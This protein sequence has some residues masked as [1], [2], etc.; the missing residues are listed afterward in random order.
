M[1]RA[2]ALVTAWARTPDDVITPWLEVLAQ[3]LR[4]AGVELE[5]L[6]PA[7]R[8]AEGGTLRGVRVHRF[9]YAPAPLEVLSHEASVPD[10]LRARP[11]WGAL[12]PGYLAAAAWETARLVE[13][14]RFDLVH[15]F[16]PLPHALPGL[17][18]ARLRGVPL[19]SSFFGVELSLAARFPSLQAP[20]RT[21]VRASDAVT[22]VS[23]FTAARLRALA[24]DVPVRVIPFGVALAPSPGLHAA[25]AETKGAASLRLLFIGR[26]VE[27]KG[28]AVLL[29]AVAR[30]PGVTLEVLGDGPLRVELERR[31]A[32][33]GGRVTFRGFV[34]AEEKA[35]QLAACDA[36]V[37]PAVLD[38]LGDT[39]GQGVVL[40]EAMA[41]GKPVIASAA[42]GIVD[43][44]RDDVEGLLVPPGDV[45]AL[46]HAVRR[47]EADPALRARLGAA[48]PA[49]VEQGFAWS[50]LR[51]EVADVYRGVLA[52]RRR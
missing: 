2:L 51:D 16:W 12:V 32:S 24:P 23:S 1:T 43:L 7:W 31:A 48:G 30:C 6:A 18:G 4:G 37:L 19:V 35:R 52:G 47:L 41:A 14:E 17:V 10:Q 45:D 29:E 39:E 27:R 8:G 5:V 44:V 9:R 15:A 11:W 20:L 26:L 36:L 34:S 22:A 50:R 46:A 33:L 3:E 25:R 42:G 38:A 40:L 21:L 49:R 28:V 13:R